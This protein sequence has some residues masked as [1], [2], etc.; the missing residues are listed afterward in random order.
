MTSTDTADDETATDETDTDE[1]TVLTFMCVRNAGRSQMATAF[2]ERERDRRGLGDRVEI[3]TGGTDPADSV[4]DVV[5]EALSEAGLDANGRTPR[6]I[7]DAAL[8]ESDFVATMGC[9][10]LELETVDTDDWALDD[11]GE[12]PIEDVREI[13][14]EI[15]RRVIAVF[16]DRFGA[17]TDA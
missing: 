7:S 14:D 17:R 9:S 10:T 13:R 11:P 3:R 5:V 15:E 16:D 2:A 8:V 1:T 6:S 12:R 4:H